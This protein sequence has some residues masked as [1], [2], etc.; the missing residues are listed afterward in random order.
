[1]SETR[2][3]WPDPEGQE[4][5]ERLFA[6]DVALRAHF[7][8][9]AAAVGLSVP[10]AHTLLQLQEPQRM[11]QIAG[12]LRCEPSHVTGLAD[13]LEECGFLRREPDPD[14]RRAKR[15]TLTTRGQELRDRLL[16]RL[17]DTAPIISVLDAEQR[18][19]LL[20]LLRVSQSATGHDTRR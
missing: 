5:V 10:Q 20:A 8:E 3:E 12:Q 11:G 9:T 17:F 4:I 1:M 15:L 13:A 14:D 6:A 2:I 7:E 18:A 16:S 19:N